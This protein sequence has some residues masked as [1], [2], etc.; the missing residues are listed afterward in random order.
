MYTFPDEIRKAYE[1]L[2]AA[3]VFDEFIDG[4]VVPLL[5]SDGFCE[6][7]GMDREHAMAWFREGQYERLHPDDVGRVARVSMEFANHRGDYDLAFRTRHPDGYHILHAIAKWLTM[8]DGT[9][10]A[11]VTYADLTANFDAISGSMED[12]PGGSVLHR[13]ADE[14]AE[15]QLPEPVCRRTGTCPADLREAA[16]YRL[17]GRHRHALLQQ[18]VRVPGGKCVSAPDGGEPD[19]RLSGGLGDARAGRS[20]PRD[21]RL[22]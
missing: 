13:P 6:L 17:R 7:I 8:P 15:P 5:I 12:Y 21:R 3:M 19:A 10:L 1:A 22:R 9:E 16:C 4:K 20:F 11:L 2:P 18:P 14:T